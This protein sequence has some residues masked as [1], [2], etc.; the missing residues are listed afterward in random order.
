MMCVNILLAGSVFLQRNCSSYQA[1]VLSVQVLRFREE[2]V[3][4]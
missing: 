2:A 3:I 1:N 4:N